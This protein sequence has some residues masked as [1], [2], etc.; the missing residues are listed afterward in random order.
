[1][2]AI[3]YERNVAR[4]AATKLI[5]MVANPKIALSPL[6]LVEI[7]PPELPGDDWVR[8]YPRL[9]GICG[10]DLATVTSNSSRYLEDFVSFPFVMGHEVVGE[11]LDGNGSMRRAVII[12]SLSCEVRGT[13]PKCRFCNNGQPQRC[14]SLHIGSISAGLQTGF[15]KET[16]GGWSQ[17]LVA[18]RSQLHDIPSTMSDED[19]VLLEPFS[20]AVHAAM[21]I[22]GN[23]NTQI[24]VIG[25]G[26]LG[27]LTIA[28]LKAIHP[29]AEIF[30][31]AKYEH[32]KRLAI[33]FGATALSHTG[34]LYRHARTIRSA[35]M[36]APDKPTDG[37]GIVFD[38]VGSA[39]SIEQALKVSA[40]G[41]DV[42]LIGM[43]KE[44]RIDL[45]PLWMK[46]ISI[47]G[48]YAYG[49]EI[50]EGEKISTFELAVRL[51]KNIELS[52]LLSATYR[53]EDYEMA[54]GHALNA[55]ER[56]SV[57]IAFDMRKPRKRESWSQQR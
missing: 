57:K 46:E 12:P 51:A 19:A 49:T 43:P 15:C 28:A 8:F 39:L 53:L 55:G 7:D 20:C 30:A 50:V 4:F 18:H 6:R 25:S 22:G 16:S 52:K 5:G 23:L 3:V 54:V 31:T 26:T 40:P 11:Y 13:T 41:A 47:K 10:S 35:Q 38:A 34:N 56:G 37:F 36:I 48:S 24:A 17:E 45:T 27:L 14:Q 21:S 33:Q 32:Q 29:N 42:I 1:M 2:K 9:S 44:S